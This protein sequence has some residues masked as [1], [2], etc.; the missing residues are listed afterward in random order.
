MLHDEHF[1]SKAK[2][3]RYGRKLAPNKEKK[4][5]EKIYQV[6]DDDRPEH[7]K[8][9]DEDDDT[10]DDNDYNDDVADDD[11]EVQKE[12]ARVE[13][14]YDPARDGGFSES[15]EDD[16]SDEE[17][18]VEYPEQIAQ[19]PDQQR[20]GAPKGEVSSRLAVV[21]L[22]WDNIRAVDLMA[23]VNGFIPKGERIL[24]VSIYPSEFGK[25]RM[26]REE[27][28]GPPKEIFAIGSHRVGTHDSAQ[29][30]SDGEDYEDEDDEER[31][32]NSI[33][34]EDKGEE[35]NSDHLRRYQL[36]RLRYFYAVLTCSSK[37][38]AEA[39]YN[40]V[41]GTEYL[42]TAN[43]F[44]LRF[45]PDDMDFSEDK[46]RDHCDRVPDRYR[47]NDF[48]TDALQHSKV[49]LTWDADD[50]E[51]K[52]AQRRAFS[53]SRADIDANDL[54]AYLGS[55]SSEDEEPSAGDNVEV[56]GTGKEL[57]ASKTSQ[58]EAERARTRA[59][60]GLGSAPA[61][62]KMKDIVP[63]GDM[64][65]TFASGLSATNEGSVFE[66]EPVQ[67]ETTVEKYARKEKERKARRKEKMQQ[68]RIGAS[69][70]DA[71]TY[72]EQDDAVKQDLGFDDPFFVE[73][74]NDKAKT[75]ARRKEQRQRRREGK[76]VEDAEAASKR[77]ELE[78]LMI[79]ENDDAQDIKH[80]D[81][82]Q[83]ERGEKIVKRKKPKGKLS[84]RHQAALEAKKQDTFAIDLQDP[85]FTA[86]YERSDFAVDPSHPRYKGTDGMK[87]LL[88]ETRKKRSRK[89][90]AS[91][92]YEESQ[93]RS[94]RNKDDDITKLLERVKGKTAE[95][96]R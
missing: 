38:C 39:V 53:G 68:A 34:K 50:V 10:D 41:D 37:Q 49:K 57:T 22:D 78:L 88:D 24:S 87:A 89:E 15:S 62:K 92:G 86:V 69:E 19:S 12:L 21:N 30:G 44:D 56:E 85:R 23:A 91:E 73:P 4:A 70:Q 90:E 94:K 27:L 32:K 5:L 43:F 63:V 20:D 82:N 66:N 83:L 14:R 71:T 74:E 42:S 11:D 84:A 67:N 31:I 59:L 8:S 58:K 96:S 1:T 9:G 55:D 65:V 13:R 48:V 18:E 29:S 45:I 72:S 16:T 79:D 2:V 51:R 6:E 54:K 77:A 93:K 35:F 36:E 61:T 3:D 17:D 75:T 81:A 7:D 52:E 60:L 28:E 64:Q 95:Q 47:P 76:T 26:E 40:A 80:F 33:V 46:A 25:G